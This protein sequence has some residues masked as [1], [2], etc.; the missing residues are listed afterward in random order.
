MLIVLVV[1]A[2]DAERADTSFLFED[3][4]K[5]KLGQGWSWIRENPKAWRVTTNGL[6]VRV[7]PGNMWGPANDARNALVRDAP[8]GRMGAIEVCAT[9]ENRPTEQYEQVDLVWYY[10]DSHMVKLGQEMVDGQLSIVMGREEKDRT[11]TIAIIPLKTFSVSVRF[12]VS[13]NRIRGQFRPE[14]TNEWQDA[15]HCD[16]PVKGPPKISIQTYQGPARAEH[17]ARI[18]EFRVAQ[19]KE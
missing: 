14:G 5:G 15:G 3:Q 12:L 2:A 11:R 13:T 9:F 1:L 7:E 18:T 17:W 10:D 19:A 6:E 4:F 8:D 16:L